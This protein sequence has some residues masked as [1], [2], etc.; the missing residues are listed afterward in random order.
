[1]SIKIL[2]GIN[3][4]WNFVNFRSG[5]IKS[6]ISHGYEIVAIAPADEYVSQLK[7]LGRRCIKLSIDNKG[8]HPGRN[9]LLFVDYFKLIRTEKPS[10]F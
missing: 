10:I 1:M 5:L 9:M 6:L 2:I 4:A 7:E 3:L 8:A